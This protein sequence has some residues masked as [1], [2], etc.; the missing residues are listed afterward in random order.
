MKKSLFKKELAITL[1]LASVAIITPIIAIACN[2]ETKGGDK[3]K[4]SPKVNEQPN[5]EATKTT[6]QKNETKLQSAVQP[7]FFK[8]DKDS[9]Y[10][11]SLN[12]PNVHGKYVL[13][14]IQAENENQAISSKRNM[15]VSNKV[16]IPFEGLKEKTKYK[17]VSIDAYDTNTSTQ[18][19]SLPVPSE[20]T[21]KFFETKPIYAT[22]FVNQ[23]EFSAFENKTFREKADVAGKSLDTFNSQQWYDFEN[24][25]Y[26]S[27]LYNHYSANGF[28][29]FDPLQAYDNGVKVTNQQKQF[30]DNKAKELSQESYDKAALKGFTLP[31]YKENSNEVLGL[32]TKEGNP[33]LQHSS[34][35]SN[36]TGAVG[37][38]R[39]LPGDK[40]KDI[41][42]QTISVGFHKDIQ[43]QIRTVSGTMWILDF[44][45][46]DD[47]SYPTKWYFATN[48]H[49]AKEILTDV[50]GISFTFLKPDAAL[51]QQQKLIKLDSNYK[52]LN[53]PGNNENKFINTVY[54]AT[55][56]LNSKP[57]DFLTPAQADKY[58][59]TDEF[60]DFAVFEVDF[61]ELVKVKNA[62]IQ[63]GG[64]PDDK[65]EQI[66]SA[67]DLAKQVTNEYATKTDKH[68]K[69]LKTSYLKDFDK[70]KGPILDNRKW[71]DYLYAVG[72]PVARG[73]EIDR[74]QNQ[75]GNAL[76]TNS[77]YGL[78]KDE[79]RNDHQF[80]ELGNLLSKH[81]GYRSF[82]DK[83]GIVDGFIAIPKVDGLPLRYGDKHYWNMALEYSLFN[84]AAGGGSSG[85]SV[86]NQKNEIVGI[87][88]LGN[89]NALVAVAAALRSEGYNYNGLYGKYNLPQYDLIFGGGKD[90][91]SSYRQ[92]LAAK[93]GDT[94]KTNIFSNGA[95]SVPEDFKF[96]QSS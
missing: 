40:Y 65:R 69:F 43:G 29:N 36:V 12:I 1:G 76:W 59:E 68:I 72:Y 87:V 49:V 91:K 7:V 66:G 58:K 44:V 92:A 5:T 20:Y 21:N 32:S 56:F 10:V 54:V 11:L 53:V 47:K 57:S 95:N 67:A 50:A 55:D 30:F 93:Y 77:F 19:T 33:S 79:Q 34:L 38:S 62:F 28:R 46:K 45:P 71:N 52:S 51:R 16:D 78:L 9:H 88:H 37:T 22:N 14:K 94:F 75:V 80:Q 61:K 74:N 8:R 4:D 84:F 2:N 70:I 90:Q 25:F 82:I 89:T 27:I 26:L 81:L 18:A 85:S 39:L 24:D 48:A 13:V 41:A 15:V 6:K 31:I 60:I 17:I 96:K 35:A 86:R 73:Q 64:D 63:Q 83:A 23:E 3:Q 42:L